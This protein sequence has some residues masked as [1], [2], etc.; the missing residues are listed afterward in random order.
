MVSRGHNATIR[1]GA[2]QPVFKQSSPTVVGVSD[3]FLYALFARIAYTDNSTVELQTKYNSQTNTIE[4]I[5]PQQAL[6]TFNQM[7]GMQRGP[8]LQTFL[9]WLIGSD[10]LGGGA[11]SLPA[12]GTAGQVLTKNSDT[13][14]DSDWQ[15]VNLSGGFF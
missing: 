3:A 7:I 5:V 12:G 10:S 11:D 9:G 4:L 1:P 15:T 14:F 6:S 13:D 2:N 8:N